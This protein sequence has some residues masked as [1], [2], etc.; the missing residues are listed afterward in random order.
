MEEGVV[1]TGPVMTRLRQVSDGDTL[2]KKDE[3]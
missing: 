2:I 3:Q 1:M